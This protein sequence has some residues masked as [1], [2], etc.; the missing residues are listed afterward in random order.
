MFPDLPYP[1]P[2]LVVPEV[3]QALEFVW[4]SQQGSGQGWEEPAVKNFPSSIYPAL[5]LPLLGS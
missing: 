5:P 4:L 1:P 2:L 3:G